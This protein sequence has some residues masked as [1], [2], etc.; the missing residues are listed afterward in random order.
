MPPELL[1]LINKDINIPAREKV[2]R[3]KLLKDADQIR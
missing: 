3:K 2:H 1:I